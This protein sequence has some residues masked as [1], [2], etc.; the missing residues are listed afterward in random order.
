M[1]VNHFFMIILRFT[2]DETR[3][4]EL[5][6]AHMAHIRQGFDEGIFLVGGPIT[7]KQGGGLIARGVSRDEIEY[8]VA[9]DPFVKE[10]VVQAEI[11]EIEALYID[12]QMEPIFL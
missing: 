4:G 8:R 5:M 12:K 7:Q 9:T 2:D 11:I 1:C 6:E 10:Q 3:A